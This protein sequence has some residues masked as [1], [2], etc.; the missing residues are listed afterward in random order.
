MYS[1]I[2]LEKYAQILE[3]EVDKVSAAFSS[4]APYLAGAAEGAIPSW[5]MA[6]HFA[7]QEADKKRNWAFGGGLAA[8]LALPHAAQGLNNYINNPSAQDFQSF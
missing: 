2:V 1:K 4:V 3:N 5:M 6:K 8:G 7:K